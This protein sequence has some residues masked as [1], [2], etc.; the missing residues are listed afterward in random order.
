MSVS[1]RCI[2]A[3]DSCTLPSEDGA[4]ETGA[5]IAS[6]ASAAPKVTNFFMV[7]LPLPAKAVMLAA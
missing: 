7:F 4:A 6:A 2:C 5:A 1:R 3:G